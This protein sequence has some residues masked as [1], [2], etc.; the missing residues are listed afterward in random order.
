[1]ID[2]ALC[3]VAILLL[4]GCAGHVTESPHIAAATSAQA[5][6]YAI[7][8]AGCNDCHTPGWSRTAGAIPDA[9]WMT[10]TDIGYHGPWGTVYP[11][12]VRLMASSMSR[13]GWIALF[14]AGPPVP[15]MP[16]WNYSHGRIDDRDLGAMYDFLKS[17]GP[18]GKDAPD[19]LSP[20]QKPHTKILVFSPVKP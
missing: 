1:M 20:S 15:V 4:G 5:G 17:L 2:R 19:D 14:Q 10:G 11:K 9:K 18:A 6:R 16:F 3:I 12:N 13:A 8:F 7:M